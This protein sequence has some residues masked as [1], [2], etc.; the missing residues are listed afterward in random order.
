MGSSKSKNLL[1]REDLEFLRSNTRYDKKTILEW[2]KGF[3][4]DCP[5]GKMNPAT[6]LDIS[7][8][9]YSGQKAA[10]FIDEIF[11]KYD[12]ENLGFIN[13]TEFLLA[14]DT[15]PNIPLGN[16]EQMVKWAFRLFDKGYG[17]LEESEFYE[18]VNYM[19]ETLESMSEKVEETAKTIFKNLDANNDG[20]VTEEECVR[21]IL[22]DKI[23]L[24]ILIQSN[25]APASRRSYP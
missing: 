23:L 3:V 4:K 20:C 7:S 9:F 6:L 22:T 2:H 25:P 15:T 5:N 10:D 13:F 8:I 21:G 14:I 17:I 11:D 19:F 18:M 1:R 12:K 16:P 24:Q